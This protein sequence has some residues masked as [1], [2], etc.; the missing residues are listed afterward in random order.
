MILFLAT[1]L[2][3][4]NPCPVLAQGEPIPAGVVES[5]RLACD[6]VLL[7]TADLAS[8]RAELLRTQAAEQRALA[9]VER[10]RAQVA[11]LEGEVQ[12]VS[13]ERDGERIARIAAQAAVESISS[14]RPPVPTWVAVAGGAGLG[15]GACWLAPG[16]PQWR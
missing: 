3:F 6:G 12:A 5:G 1:A 7:A 16:A 9:E 13:A 14:T 4:A 2:A 15:L 11:L 8:L 10:Q